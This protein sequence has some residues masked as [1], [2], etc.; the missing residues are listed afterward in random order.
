M[1][2]SF[3]GRAFSQSAVALDLAALGRVRGG[4]VSNFNAWKPP[5]DNSVVGVADGPLLVTAT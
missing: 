2:R 3:R 5:G 1:M 4:L